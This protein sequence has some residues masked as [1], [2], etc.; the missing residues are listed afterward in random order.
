M[1]RL[2]AAALVILWTVSPALAAGPDDARWKS[3]TDRGEYAFAVGNMEVAESELRTALEIAQRFPEGDRRLETSLANLGRLY[4]HRGRLDQAQPLY[5]LEVAA[6]EA[7]LGPT[8]AALLDPLAAVARVALASGDAPTAEAALERYLA[9]AD[10]TRKADPRQHR[11]VLDLLARQRAILGRPE[12]ALP[13]KRQSAALLD[14]DRSLTD[15]ERAE[16][17]D[18]LARLEL[19][20]GDPNDAAAA[21][22][23]AAAAR[24]AAGLPTAPLLARSA[25]AALAAGRADL[26]RSLAGRALEAKPDPTTEL[27]A[28]ATVVDAA[29]LSMPQGDL[30]PSDLVAAGQDSPELAAAAVALATLLPLQESALGA[31]SPQARQTL[32][33]SALVAARRGRPDE[34]ADAWRRVVEATPKATDAH[35]N[36]RSELVALLAAAG[37]RAEAADVNAELIADLEAAWGAEDPRLLPPLRRQQELYTELKQ[38]RE[39]R[40]VKKR[41]RGLERALR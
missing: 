14:D 3:H 15:D 4:E 22:D 39:A 2:A 16:V 9:I 41:I 12:E 32:E 34:A 6:R 8:H 19:A 7:R 5:Q 28:R 25:R 30:R 1:P 38:K 37:Q 36:A 26:A 11:L 23:R 35:R 40:E 21:V 33:R 17:L 13:L 24:A 20:F 31:D 29:W 18:E 10:A 27:D